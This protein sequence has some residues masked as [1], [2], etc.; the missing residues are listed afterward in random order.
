VL[1]HEG[2]VSEG[3]AMNVFI[4]R[5]G[6]AITPPVTENILEGITR[7]TAIELMQKELNMQVIERPIDRTEVYLCDEIFFTGTA[8][9]ITIITR[10]DHRVIGD[11]QMGSTGSQ[12]R[13]IFDDIV[14]GKYP[15]YKEWNIPVY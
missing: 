9:Q 14:R 1:T 15:Q 4:V 5:D 8:A 10:V 6:I 11:G 3:S 7:R 2:H 13:Q 12:L